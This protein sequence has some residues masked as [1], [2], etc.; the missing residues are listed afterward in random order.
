M[1]T[2]STALM[3]DSE[4]SIAIITP[5]L[6]ALPPTSHKLPVR[7]FAA[8]LAATLPSTC[9]PVPPNPLRPTSIASYSRWASSNRSLAIPSFSFWMLIIMEYSGMPIPVSWRRISRIRS[10]T[11]LSRSESH[12]LRMSEFGK[13]KGS[14][15]QSR[16]DSGAFG[17]TWKRTSSVCSTE[18]MPLR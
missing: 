14:F 12:F 9:A 7:S 8:V 18:I 13:L 4:E 17:M 3:A 15:S 5:P 10:R 1:D 2:C 11:C 16:N 6:P